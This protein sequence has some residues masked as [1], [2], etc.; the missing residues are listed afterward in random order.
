MKRKGVTI[1][2]SSLKPFVIAILSDVTLTTDSLIS[3]RAFTSK[4][5]VWNLHFRQP[6]Q[7]IS[8]ESFFLSF[9]L[10][11]DKKRNEKKEKGK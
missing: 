5:I 4:L 10:K 8:D 9:Y 7:L 2:V 3:L 6:P 11:T 1:I